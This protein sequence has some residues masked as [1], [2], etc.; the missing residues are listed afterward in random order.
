MRRRSRFGTDSYRRLISFPT[1]G[2][3]TCVSQEP[4]WPT[5]PKKKEFVWRSPQTYLNP[6]FLERCA[7]V[8][9]IIDH[10]ESKTLE[11]VGERSRIIGTVMLPYIRGDEVW[12]VCRIYGQEIIDYIQKAR[13]G[14]HQPVGCVLWCVRWGRSS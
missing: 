13:G 14:I 11:D 4:E 1:C 7:G 12:G 10:P 6:Q 9:V 8:P 5:A 2:W 3:L